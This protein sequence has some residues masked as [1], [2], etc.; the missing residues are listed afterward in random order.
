MDKPV[1][2]NHKDFEENLYD[3]YTHMKYKGVLFTGTLIKEGRKIEYK[4]GNANG[5]SVAHY[6]N[7]QI[8]CDEIYENGDY[9]SGKE[10]YKNG[11]LKYDSTGLEWYSNGIRKKDSTGSDILR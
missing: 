9:I 2:Y 1:E 6:E 8:E 10:W 7:G 4:N 3:V 5:K 11:Q